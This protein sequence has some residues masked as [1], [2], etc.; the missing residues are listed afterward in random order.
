VTQPADFVVVDVSAMLAQVV[1]LGVD[2]PRDTD[3][4]FEAA[5]RQYV[6]AEFLAEKGLLAEGVSAERT[7][8]LTIR[9]L[10]I[11]EL[12][13]KFVRNDFH[14]W[15]GSIDKTETPEAKMVEKLERRWTKFI[16]SQS[17]R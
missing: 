3:W 13:Q 2:G 6:F 12:G 16:A 15:L 8:D 11:N 17:L 14:K 4:N 7:P 9:W 10:Q 1:T 5:A